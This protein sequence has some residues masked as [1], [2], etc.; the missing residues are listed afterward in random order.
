MKNTKTP[1]VPPQTPQPRA[2]AQYHHTISSSDILAAMRE[3]QAFMAQQQSLFQEER[4]SN[5]A[6]LREQHEFMAEQQ[7]QLMSFLVKNPRLDNPPDSLN[8]RT[9]PKT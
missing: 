3:Q 5:Q 7:C 6:A 1:L 2:P 9:G 8:S 4:I